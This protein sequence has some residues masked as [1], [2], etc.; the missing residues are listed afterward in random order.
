[1]RTK[2]S[3]TINAT[4]SDLFKAASMLYSISG[5]IADVRIVVDIAWFVANKE[6][7]LLMPNQ[8][9]ATHAGLLM[10]AITQVLERALNG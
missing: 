8:M 7:P 2:T 9:S 5:E 4:N 3:S 6:I 1:M 10:V